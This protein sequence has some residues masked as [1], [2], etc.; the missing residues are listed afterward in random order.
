MMGDPVGDLVASGDAD[1]LVLGS[2]GYG[3]ATCRCWCVSGR[4]VRKSACPV[5]VVPRGVERPLEDL[6]PPVSQMEP[7]PPAA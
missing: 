7:A 5:I 3:P 1:L 4:M 2:R 6:F